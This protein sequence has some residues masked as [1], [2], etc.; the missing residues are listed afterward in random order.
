MQKTDPTALIETLRPMQSERIKTDGSGS[1]SCS[2]TSGR[3]LSSEGLI[4]YPISRAVSF[5][6]NNLCLTQGLE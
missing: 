6:F 3:L 2:V 4:G 5:A 1:F